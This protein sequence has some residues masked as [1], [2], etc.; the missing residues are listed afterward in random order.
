MKIVKPSV[1][2]IEPSGYTLDDIYKHI[3]KCAK[4]CYKSEAKIT[5]SSAYPFVQ[6]LIKAGHTAMLEFG[7]VYLTIP[8][9]VVDKD[10]ALERFINTSD[11]PC[12]D[13]EWDVNNYYVTTNLRYIRDTAMGHE[14]NILKY[15][16]TP[17]PLH[18]KR[19]TLKF[20]TSIGIVRELIRHRHFSFANEST[21][22]CNYSKDKF[23][24]EVSFIEPYWMGNARDMFLTACEEAEGYYLDLLEDGLTP[25]E[26]REVLP[27]STK[28][29][30]CMCGFVKDWVHFFSLRLHEVT[31]KVHPDMKI[32]AQMAYDKIKDYLI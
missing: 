22:Y 13:W 20:V 16:V 25:Q 32:L 10:R 11:S 31:G 12:L 24:N 15:L 21:R 29:E 30:L 3:E 2:L 17:T 28:S 1:E 23:N 8:D 9:D 26:A 5:D 27:L 19:V 6:R 4:V 18:P 7:T 14:E